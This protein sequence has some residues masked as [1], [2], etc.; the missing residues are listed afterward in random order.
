MIRLPFLSPRRIRTMWHSRNTAAT[1]VLRRSNVVFALALAVVAVGLLA[2]AP[3][4]AAAADP[5]DE[6]L[7]RQAYRVAEVWLDRAEIPNS[8]IAVEVEGLLAVHV[9][10]REGTTRLGQGTAVVGEPAE[11]PESVDAMDLL[12]RGLRAA[13][14]DAAANVDDSTRLSR[15]AP[16][17]SLDIQFAHNLQRFEVDGLHE[18]PDRFTPGLQGLAMRSGSQWAWSFPG[19]AVATNASIRGQLNRLLGELDLPLAQLGSVG[20]PEGTPLYRFDAIHLVRPSSDAELLALHRGNRLLPTVPLDDAQ[21]T[22][23]TDQLLSHLF[24][25]Q[26]SDGRFYGSYLPAADRYEPLHAAPIDASTAAYALARASRL[27]RLDDQTRDAAADAARRAV[28]QI[29]A[30]DADDEAGPVT[31][32][33]SATAM[34][35]LA[36]LETPGVGDLRGERD[37]LADSLLNRQR[38]DGSFSGEPREQDITVASHAI[39]TAALVRLYDRTREADVLESAHL[40]LDALWQRLAGEPHIG[41]AMPWLI[42]AELDLER[43]NQ[44]SGYRNRFTR[45]AAMLWREQVQPLDDLAQ[46]TPDVVGGFGSRDGLFREPTWQSARILAGQALMLHNPGF[47]EAD[48]KPA[49]IVNTALG[50]RF[51]AQLTMQEDGAFYAREPERAIGGTRSGFTNHRQPLYATAM[52]LLATAEFEHAL[53]RLND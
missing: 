36:M 18:L 19:S 5:I 47:V 43:L 13:L 35:L 52:S 40:S 42:V 53:T 37:R 28:E 21:L 14:R 33:P 39:V 23:L 11:P 12:R 20:T 49:W 15:I 48:Q 34:T 10:L 2:A 6:S 38:E 22:A 16:D 51:I 46:Q 45:A 9:T 32:D 17:M 50:A 26:R 24:G 25:R 7:A 41:D 29:I 3:R 44:P 8:S 1:R 30:T 31:A 27:D 4:E